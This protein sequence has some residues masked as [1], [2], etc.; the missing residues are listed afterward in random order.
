MITIDSIGTRHRLYRTVPS[1][2][3]Y[4][5]PFGHSQARLKGGVEGVSYSGPRDVCGPR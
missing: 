1:P 4:D 3:Q 5:V 2:T